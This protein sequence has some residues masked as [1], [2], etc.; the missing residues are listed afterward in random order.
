M[1]GDA[2]EHVAEV[3]EW[4]DVMALAGGNQ[5]KEHGRGVAAGVGAAEQPDIR[6]AT[7]LFLDIRRYQGRYPF[8]SLSP[9]LSEAGRP[10]WRP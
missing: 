7:R 3:G 9:G 2:G 6:D 10:V 1:G 8:I 4:I 5:R